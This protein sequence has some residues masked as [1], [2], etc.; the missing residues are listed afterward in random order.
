MVRKKFINC[1][2]STVDDCLYGTVLADS[3]LAYHPV[4][5]RC[6]TFLSYK[7]FQ[8]NPRVVLRRDLSHI[9]QHGCVGIVVGGGSGHEPFSVGLFISLN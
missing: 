4:S 9:K 3:Q 2:D 6:A 1:V 5:N 8:E 7:N